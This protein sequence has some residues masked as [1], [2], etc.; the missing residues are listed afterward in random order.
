MSKEEFLNILADLFATLSSDADENSE[1]DIKDM[2]STVSSISRSH[3]EPSDSRLSFEETIAY[4]N[5]DVSY[6]I[7]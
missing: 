4:F 3:F 1:I 7:P 6:F 5:N 2:R